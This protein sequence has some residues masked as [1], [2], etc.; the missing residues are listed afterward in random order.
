M[1]ARDS[2]E[3]VGKTCSIHAELEPKQQARPHCLLN[4]VLQLTLITAVEQC[5]KCSALVR[6]AELWSLARVVF[7]R[8]S[9][10]KVNANVSDCSNKTIYTM[11]QRQ[12]RFRCL[13]IIITTK[14]STT[15]EVEL[16]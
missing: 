1:K 5:Y 14:I 13:A 15:I 4:A 11:Q 7:L 9:A 6:S 16:K 10:A 12:E 3:I 2:P 8:L